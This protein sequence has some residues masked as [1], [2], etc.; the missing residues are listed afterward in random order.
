MIRRPPSSKR[1]DTLF[2][3][4]TRFQSG[5][6]RIVVEIMKFADARETR[7]EHFGIG[8]RGDRRDILGCQPVEETVHDLAPAPEIVVGPA[9]AFRKAGHAALETVAVDVARSEEHTSERQ[10]LMRN[11]YAGLCLTK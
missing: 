2:P 11:S 1:T 8:L 3:Y 10:S 4:T 6:R 9:A 7:L 5:A